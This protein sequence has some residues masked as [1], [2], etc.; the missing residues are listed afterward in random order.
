MFFNKLKEEM[1]EE[2]SEKMG[3]IFTKLKEDVINGIL[4]ANKPTEELIKKYE[5]TQWKNLKPFEKSSIPIFTY[6]LRPSNFLRKL[7]VVSLSLKSQAIIT[8]RIVMFSLLVLC[9]M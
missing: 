3:M 6:G 2:F 5:H 1:R 9:I 8:S 7:R 4:A